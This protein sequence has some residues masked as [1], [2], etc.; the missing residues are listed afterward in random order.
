MTP[1]E[2]WVD[3]AK[4]GRNNSGIAQI[5]EFLPEVLITEMNHFYRDD[6]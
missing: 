3:F 4:V 2:F 1:C 5:L 6:V